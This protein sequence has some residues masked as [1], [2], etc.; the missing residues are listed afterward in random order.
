MSKL[1]NKEYKQQLNKLHE[2]GVFN[3][4]KASYNIV[5]RF[6]K[7]FSPESILD[8]G[9]GHGGLIRVISYHHPQIIVDG[10]DPG[11]KKFQ[12][13]SQNKFDAVIS[14]DVLEH[15]EP[16]HLDI[17]LVEIDKKIQ[18]YAFFRIACYPA[19]KKL[20]DGRNAHLII[21]KPS[22]WRAKIIQNMNV[23]IFREKITKIDKG[24]GIKGYNYDLIIKNKLY[25][26]ANYLRTFINK[27]LYRK[28]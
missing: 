25:R 16:A 14:T 9:C 26:E 7:R 8:F 4:G 21:K 27:Y 1:I 13:L 11:N 18:K 3:N 6:I 19:R 20:P 23:E 2:E 15:I 28:I 24:S 12:I 17:T 22:W 5:K 10:Y